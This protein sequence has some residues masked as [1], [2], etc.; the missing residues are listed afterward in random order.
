MKR[1]IGIGALIAIGLVVWW[2]MRSKQTQASELWPGATYVAESEYEKLHKTVPI[3]ASV[4]K[5]LEV[6]G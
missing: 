4:E 1:G 2:L 6:Y 3:T 5:V